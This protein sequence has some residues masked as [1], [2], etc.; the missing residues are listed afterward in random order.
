MENGNTV[1][2]ESS[3]REDHVLEHHL[4]SP[5]QTDQHTG[6]AGYQGSM[7][8]GR[9]FPVLERWAANLR[10]DFNPDKNSE[11]ERALDFE[12]R[13]REAIQNYRARQATNNTLPSSQASSHGPYHNRYMKAKAA[14][15]SDRPFAPETEYNSCFPLNDPREYLIRQNARGL[16]KDNTKIRHVSSSKLPFEH[17]PEGYDIHNLGLSLSTDLLHVKK[18]FTIMATHD[19]YTHD[20]KEDKLSASAVESQAP[21]WNARI[22]TMIKKKYEA[23]KE[24]RT[25]DLK[26]DFS[27]FIDHLKLFDA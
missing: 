20:G 18:A 10:E 13:K 5:S 7:D 4:P 11:V 2:K 25:A 24:A 22:N 21:A 3:G 12:R 15:A 27:T 19:S 8:S 1:G 14:L 9:G 16:P 23:K 26:I 6:E 17:I